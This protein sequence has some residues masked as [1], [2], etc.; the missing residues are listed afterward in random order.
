[1]FSEGDD[2]ARGP[3]IG[4]QSV[5]PA[6]REPKVTDLVA[7]EHRHRPMA[8]DVHGRLVVVAGGYEIPRRGPPE[9]RH[10]LGID[11]TARRGQLK[12]V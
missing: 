1:V 10:I 3:A 2:G 4:L 9:I 5:E 11:L 8:G 7:V 6:L 12:H